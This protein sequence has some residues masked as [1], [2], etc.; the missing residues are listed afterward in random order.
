MTAVEIIE[1]IKRLPKDEQ[2]RVIDFAR[3]A[4]T[5]IVLTPEQ[6]GQLAKQMVETP[7]PAEWYS[8]F[9]QW[10]DRLKRHLAREGML[11]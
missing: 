5:G 8:R 2:K 7:D 3:N 1:E 11:A 6:L 4:S 10:Q 9:P